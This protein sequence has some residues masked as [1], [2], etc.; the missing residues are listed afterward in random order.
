MPLTLETRSEETML[1]A[2]FKLLKKIESNRWNSG[3]V[4]CST[5]TGSLIYFDNST[6]GIWTIRFDDEDESPEDDEFVDEEPPEALTE[7]PTTDCWANLADPTL[8]IP[9]RV[10]ALYEAADDDAG[11]AAAYLVAEISRQDI[12][13]EW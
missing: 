4:T 9:D 13:E 11:R 3:V 7:K 1:Q 2:V 10:E 5:P 8:A 12:P 6:P